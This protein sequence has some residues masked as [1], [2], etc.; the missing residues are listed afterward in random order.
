M[1]TEEIVQRFQSVTGGNGQWKACCPAHEDN[2]ASLSITAGD[3]GRTLLFCHAGCRVTD[4][5]LAAELEMRDLFTESDRPSPKA[6]SQKRIVETYPYL[7]EKG[8]LLYEVVRYDPKDFRQR[9]P[10]GNAGWIWNTKSVRQVPYGL[11]N[12]LSIGS[13]ETIY[14]V[15]GEKDVHSLQRCSLHGTCNAGGAG[16]WIDDFAEYFKH[17]NVVVIPDN[18]P[19]GKN[20]SP[21]LKHG[22]AILDSVSKAALSTKALIL[23]KKDVSDWFKA[24]HKRH[25]LEELVKKAPNWT[26]GA[27]LAGPNG[28]ANLASQK[29]SLKLT[30]LSDISPKKIDWLWPNV[31]ALGK[32]SMLVGDPGQSKSLCSIDLCARFTQ[33]NVWPDGAAVGDPGT[34]IYLNAEDDAADTTR[35]RFDEAGGDPTRTIVIEA[36]VNA[37]GKATERTFDLRQ[38]VELLEEAIRQIEGR[39]LVVIDPISN[40]LPGLDTHKDS[41]VRSALMPLVEM[42]RRTN[43]AC[44]LL[45]HLNKSTSTSS[46][47]YRVG[48]SIAYVGVARSVWAITRDPNDRQSSRRLMLPVKA[49][50]AP[51]ATG[52][53]YQ[54]K[55]GMNGDPFLSWEEGAIDVTATEALAPDETRHR[56]RDAPNRIEAEEWLREH[57][58]GGPKPAKDVED[59]AGQEGHT[60]R[61]LMRAKKAIGAQSMKEEDRWVWSLVEECQL[62]TDSFC[63]GTLG[64][65][66]T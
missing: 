63:G 21:G 23:D 36:T 27:S 10:D 40:Y 54:I 37:G 62:A 8:V 53:A 61:T 50:L 13:G 60:K 15:E 28:A 43:A 35:P 18:D 19:P 59:A 29:P 51:D 34:I 12:I 45:A 4:I 46:A 47:I 3:N 32:V 55:S 31:L 42:V 1:T 11:P 33:G 24:G 7:D 44:L 22:Q 16:K 66:A 64:N 14:I 6:S 20:G 5:A 56:V 57:L 26:P 25:E 9:R 58:A 65:V 49:N 30:R 17:L 38:D 2:K 39:V 41:E 48:G 52:F